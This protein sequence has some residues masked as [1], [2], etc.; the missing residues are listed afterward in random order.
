MKKQSIL[1]LDDEEGFRNE[2]KEYLKDRVY[3]IFTSGLPSDALKIMEHNKIDIAI[4]DIRLPEMDGLSVL[5]IIKQKSP[6]TEII[7]MTGF[8]EMEDVVKALR[9]GASDFF[10]KPFRPY[11]IK[12][13]ID[14][15]SRYLTVSQEIKN[16][17]SLNGKE[18]QIIGK[19]SVIEDII[20]QISKV[21]RSD[22][23]TV[24]ITGESG[25]GKELVAKAIHKLSNRN[26]NKF[27]TVNCSSIPEELFEN[28][29]FGHK[30]GSYTD[31]KDDQTGLFEAAH[32]GTLFLDEIGD[33]KYNLQSKFLRVIEEKKI[34]RLG[35]HKEQNV[36]VRIIAATNH[37]LESMVKEKLFRADLYHR[38]NIFSINIPPLRERMED[39]PLLVEHFIKEIS[40][41]AGKNITKID[42]KV[43]KKLK[44]YDFPGNV[45]ELKNMIERAVILSD[46]EVL[47]ED[48]FVSFAFLWENKT[49]EFDDN[50]EVLELAAVEKNHITK[51]LKKTKYNKAKTARLL[52]IS[53]QALDRKIAKYNINV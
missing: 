43:F 26:N 34:S 19:S 30:K 5:Q 9:L 52:N 33:L 24:L 20:G 46:N 53:R 1:I 37:N 28:E 10:N 49:P 48:C 35:T 44:S 22:D 17:N 47:S 15:V 8:G 32:N 12:K 29:F 2:L 25:T 51:V 11:D 3:R 23:A 13:A 21:A 40:R 45:R 14:R 42:S 18:I 6:E 41:K 27:V 4:L 7:M 31:A 38:L 36:D 16:N 50:T 39:V